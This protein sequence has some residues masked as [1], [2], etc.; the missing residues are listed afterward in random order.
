MPDEAA[1]SFTRLVAIKPSD[2]KEELAVRANSETAQDANALFRSSQMLGYEL[3]TDFRLF[4]RLRLPSPTSLRRAFGLPRT[5]V[6][7]PFSVS[8]PLHRV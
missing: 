6:A 8:A 7:A 2:K 5:S 4:S 3:A 1:G